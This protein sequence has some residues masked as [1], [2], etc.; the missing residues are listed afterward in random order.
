MLTHVYAC[1]IE[2]SDTK[3]KSGVY[4]HVHVH[5]RVLTCIVY[6]Y[7]FPSGLSGH[8]FGNPE[9]IM[10]PNDFQAYTHAE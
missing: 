1:I 7:Y 5:V 9:R 10:K 4:I 6:V 8:T 3:P 2:K